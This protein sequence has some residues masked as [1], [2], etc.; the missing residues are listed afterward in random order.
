VVAAVAAILASSAPTK[1]AGAEDGGI[2]GVLFKDLPIDEFLSGGGMAA[3]FGANTSSQTYQSG[4]HGNGRTADKFVNDPCLDPAPPGLDRTVQSEPEIAVLNASTSM[5]K[6]IVA[7]YNNTAGFNDRNRGLSGYAYSTDGG[8]TW[9]D[10][11]GLPPAISGIGTADDDGKDA[12]FG[13]PSLVVHHATQRFFYAS[14][15]KLPDGSY[16]LSVNRGTFQVAPRQGTESVANTRCLNNVTQTGVP[17]PPPPT[18]ERIIWEPPVAA[19][20][21]TA[22]VGGVIVNV[23]KSPDFLDKPWLSIDQTTGTLYLNYTRFALDGET[24]L[25]LARCTGCALKTSFTSTDWDGPYTIV[26]NELDTL[27][28]A[29][30]ATTTSR[31][32]V[33]GGPPRLIVTWFARTFLLAAAGTSGLPGANQTET[34]QRIRYAYSD[35]D[36]KTWSS[37]KTSAAVNPQAEPLDYNRGRTSG[38]ANVPSIAVDKGADDGG[39]TSSETTRPGFGNVYITYFSGKDRLP[40][41]SR[42]ADIFVSRSI[43]NGTTFEAS[44]KVN[45]DPGATSHVFPTLQVNKNGSVYVGWLDRRNDPTNVLTEAWASVSKDNGLTFGRNQVQSDVATSWG[46]RSDARPNFGDYNSSELLGFN[47]FVMIWA[48]GRFRAP[49]GQAATP[50]T[51]FTIT[52]GLGG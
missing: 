6:K 38:I 32:G 7:G 4:V 30:M 43:D 37:A 42:A 31:P 50:D 17:D 21:P 44:V 41:R 27:N 26:P 46:V 13:D 10:G 22:E 23:P 39:F 35:D 52:S 12:Y 9:I 45:D 3:L 25:E 40:S 36:G 2:A 18:Q 15:Y 28:Q 24:P 8:N 11:G 48:D 19:A 33:A 34:Q 5:G 20:R 47:T 16:T 49:G 29:T 51:I 1:T 14:I